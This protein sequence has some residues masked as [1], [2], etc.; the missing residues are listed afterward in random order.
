[1]S[2]NRIIDDKRPIISAWSDS[3][4]EMG[5]QVGHKGVTWIEPYE[6]NGQMAPVTWL[7][8]WKGDKL[9]ARLNAASMVE[10]CYGTILD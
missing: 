6:E 8:V 7:R 10:I 3:P 9:A 2:T 5:A 4:A 1:M